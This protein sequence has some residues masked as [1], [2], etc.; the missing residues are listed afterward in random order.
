LASI[1]G[2]LREDG[3]LL[4]EA[5]NPSAKRWL[6]WTK[7]RTLRDIPDDAGKTVTVWTETLETQGRRVRFEMHY[8]WKD[9]G[10]E[11]TSESTLAFRSEEEIRRSLCDAGFI[12]ERVYGNWDKSAV[13]DPSPEL[14]FV[15]NRT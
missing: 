11:L 9:S 1:H 8:L 13:R 7:A 10:E 12:I 14:I 3:H 5:R 2:A 4:F 15:A 6:Q